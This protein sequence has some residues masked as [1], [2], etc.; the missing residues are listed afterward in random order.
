[1]PVA[2]APSAIHRDTA[3]ELWMANERTSGSL[4]LEMCSPNLRHPIATTELPFRQPPLQSD[5]L[6]PQAHSE[7]LLLQRLAAAWATEEESPRTGARGGRLSGV[8]H[9]K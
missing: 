8:C 2:S 1:M 3:A 9:Y 4:D 6:G 5:Y 7:I